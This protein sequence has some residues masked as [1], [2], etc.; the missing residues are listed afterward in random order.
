MDA[1]S[2][3]H[4]VS[5]K[6][7][8][9]AAATTLVV[10]A[11]L[12]G[13]A[14]PTVAAQEARFC[15]TV[16]S[17]QPI[18]RDVLAAIESGEA[19]IILVEEAAACAGAPAGA[20]LEGSATGTPTELLASL[21]IEPESPAGYDRDLFR[22][23]VDADG[24][25]C[26]ARDEVLMGESLTSV[27]VGAGCAIG[28]GSW[29]SAY[30]GTETSDPSDLDIDHV[31]P[32]AEAWRS[33]AADWDD[34]TREAFAN[35][36]ADDRVLRAVSAGSNRSKS[37]QDPAEWLPSEDAFLCEYVADWVAV[38][39]RWDLATDPGERAAIE[40]VL[41]GC[42][43][44]EITVTDA[45]FSIETASAP[46]EGVEPAPTPRPA[47]QNQKPRG[48]CHPSYPGVCIEPPPPDL[49]C[50]D[51]PE[52]RFQVR[53]PDPHRLDGDADGIGCES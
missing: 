44:E 31:V 4:H 29:R 18:E 23:W 40:D 11:L 53:G 3:R 9:P 26:D 37:D 22:H 51:I 32:L 30:D 42:P 20:V 46:E 1:R 45:V 12:S 24:D 36:L 35:D 38:K 13:F 43:A 15:V 2:R 16:R 19:T 6:G 48:D 7:I 47:K 5:M 25:G 17:D 14:G 34:Q 33:G 52:R 27:N 39:V 50:A 21:H 49:D 10:G 41:A 8:T 28:G